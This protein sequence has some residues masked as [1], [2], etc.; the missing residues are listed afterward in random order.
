MSG[1]KQASKLFSVLQV[2]GNIRNNFVY[3]ATDSAQCGI[4][5]LVKDKYYILSGTMNDH[6]IHEHVYIIYV[7]NNQSK[8]AYIYE[9]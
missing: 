9:P 8:K 4:T 3:T 5:N 1:N 7:K 2:T 6:D